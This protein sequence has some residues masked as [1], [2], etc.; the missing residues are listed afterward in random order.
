[1]VA[2]REHE[3]ATSTLIDRGLVWDS[4]LLARHQA[5]MNI[6]KRGCGDDER[7]LLLSYVI[8][9]TEWITAILDQALAVGADGRG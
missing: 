7:A 2:A 6:V 9:P 5:A 3:R 8:W 1:M 4:G